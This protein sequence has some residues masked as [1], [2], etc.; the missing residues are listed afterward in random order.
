[1]HP[2]FLPAIS[3][4]AKKTIIRKIRSWHLQLKSDK[5]IKDLAMMVSAELRG[6]YN[7]YGKFYPSEMI[8]IWKQLNWYLVQWI[9]RKYKRLARHKRRA[10]EYL[11]R[12]AHTNPNLFIHW[13]LGFMPGAKM[14]GAE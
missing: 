5:T 2:N 7:Y 14:A 13:K 4:N 12:I 3:N 8:D 1:M 6:W 11:N 10:R 9:R